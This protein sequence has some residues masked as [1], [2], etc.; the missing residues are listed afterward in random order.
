MLIFTFMGV[1]DAD[2]VKA[3][4][5]STVHTAIIV[6]LVVIGII[7]I[8]QSLPAFGDALTTEGQEFGFEPIGGETTPPSGELQEGDLLTSGGLTG[9]KTTT[10]AGI[11][12]VFNPSVLSVVIMFLIFAGASVVISRGKRI[13]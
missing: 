8:A 3:A 7:V 11:E 12:V 10:E 13:S 9:A 1:K 6:G 2:F 4:K 5:D